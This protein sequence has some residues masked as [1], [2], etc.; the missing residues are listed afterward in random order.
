MA[1]SYDVT[2]KQFNGVDYDDLYF[3]ASDSFKFGGKTSEEYRADILQNMASADVITV[4]GAWSGGIFSITPK[5][6]TPLQAVILQPPSIQGTIDLMLPRIAN[7][8]LGYMNSSAEGLFICGTTLQIKSASVLAGSYNVLAYPLP[9]QGANYWI[10]NTSGTW[11]V[12]YSGRYNLYLRGGGGGSWIYNYP[13]SVTPYAI[14][15]S[16]GGSGEVFSGI[17]LTAGEVIPVTIGQG[18]NFSENTASPASQGGSTTFGNYSV[19]GGM[20]GSQNAGGAGSG[21][22][23][24]N[25]VLVNSSALTAPIYVAPGTVSQNRGQFG[26]GGT[27]FIYKYN[28]GA[29]A[30]TLYAQPGAVIVEYLGA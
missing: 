18:G 28:S 13:T 11:T 15:A 5:V 24:Q 6:N 19:A 3:R 29:Q 8:N 1:T 21:N 17:S 4:N 26:W 7:T 20:G 16:G 25:G 23:G 30:M 9:L 22:Q 14:V 12:P 27:G 2:A 10:I